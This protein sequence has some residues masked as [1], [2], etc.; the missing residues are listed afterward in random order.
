MNYLNGKYK[1]PNNRLLIQRMLLVYYF[2]SNI[3]PWQYLE[4]WDNNVC[5]LLKTEVM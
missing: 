1:E 5:Q 4:I 3:V 2:P